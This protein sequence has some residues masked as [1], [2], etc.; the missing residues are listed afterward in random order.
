MLGALIGFVGAAILV[1]DDGNGERNDVFHSLLIVLATLCYALNS[2]ILGKYLSGIQ[3]F[4]LSSVVFT[5]WLA[6][7]LIILGIT[8]FY[9]DFSGTPEQ[10]KGLG[11]V[12]LLAI[13]G[14]AIAMI[15]F[16]KLIQMTSAIF[17]SVVTYLMPIIAVLWG[18]LDG[19]KLTW[20]HAIGGILIL[21]GVYLIQMKSPRVRKEFEDL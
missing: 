19:E 13:F 1:S 10:W 2:L 3:S 17:A 5:I 4:K 7:A 18:I 11:F 12:S 6:P 20:I 8:G 16:Y 9:Q 14:T 15:L 21:L